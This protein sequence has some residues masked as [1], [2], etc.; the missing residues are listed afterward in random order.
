[1]IIGDIDLLFV[2]WVLGSV[3]ANKLTGAVAGAT[4]CGVLAVLGNEVIGIR[5]A[6]LLGGVIALVAGVA[7]TIATFWLESR[8]FGMFL[9]WMYYV[10]VPFPDSFVDVGKLPPTLDS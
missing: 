4:A 6:A 3:V 9:A 5:G 1:M 2:W 8:F 7:L 10:L